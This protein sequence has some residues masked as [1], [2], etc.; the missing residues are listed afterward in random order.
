MTAQA[1]WREAL[2]A[3]VLERGPHATPSA[4]RHPHSLLWGG[5]HPRKPLGSDKAVRAP[6]SPQ[7]HTLLLPI[8]TNWTTREP[9]LCS[10]SSLV[11]REAPHSEAK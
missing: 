9:R 1:L 3:R 6:G 8:S 5:A 11:C 4:Q 2:S 10:K 7:T